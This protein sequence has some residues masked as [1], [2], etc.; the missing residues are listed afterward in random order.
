MVASGV[1]NFLRL[2]CSAPAPKAVAFFGV[3][4]EPRARAPVV[5]VQPLRMSADAHFITLHGSPRPESM[6]AGVRGNR[7]FPLHSFQP[8]RLRGQSS[9]LAAGTQGSIP[10]RP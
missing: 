4:I 9:Q 2:E 10:E 3:W 5:S 7:V 6:R 1:S 8:V